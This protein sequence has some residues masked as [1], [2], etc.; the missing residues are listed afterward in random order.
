MARP[1]STFIL[2]SMM[3]LS[4]LRSWGSKRNTL[5]LSRLG[6]KAWYMRGASGD[7]GE[8]SFGPK[9]LVKFTSG[10]GSPS[11]CLKFSLSWSMN[12]GLPS[13]SSNLWKRTSELKKGVKLSCT[14]LL[15]RPVPTVYASSFGFICLV[16]RPRLCMSTGPRLLGQ[17]SISHLVYATGSSEGSG[18]LFE[19]GQN[20]ISS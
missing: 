9:L 12:S 6:C 16:L 19:P 20:L 8:S 15:L 14:I 10:P 1:R 5:Q 18:P 2:K 7:I 17:L 11:L 3:A 13:K 4:H